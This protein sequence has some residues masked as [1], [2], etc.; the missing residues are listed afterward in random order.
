MWNKGLFWRFFLLSFFPLLFAFCY[1]PHT[2]IKIGIL[3]IMTN[4]V[5]IFHCGFTKEDFFLK[6]YLFYHFFKTNFFLEFLLYYIR[7]NIY[8]SFFFLFAFC[9]AFRFSFF[10]RFPAFCRFCCFFGG[11]W[12]TPLRAHLRHN[13]IVLYS[14]KCTGKGGNCIAQ[15]LFFEF[16][17]S[18]KT[19]NEKRIEHFRCYRNNNYYLFFQS[20]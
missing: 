9:P 1:P 15:I 6:M 7:V 18:W 14:N 2:A 5:Q 20:V 11:L 10:L 12:P 8:W 19:Q 13:Q 4:Q 16:D 17:E 3:Y